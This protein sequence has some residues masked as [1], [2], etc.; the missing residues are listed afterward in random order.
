MPS[1]SSD[2]HVVGFLRLT[3]RNWVG[4]FA[5]LEATA[6]F[7]FWPHADDLWGAEEVPVLR[8]KLSFCRI[9]PLVS[10]CLSI[11]KTSSGLA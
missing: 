7:R 3:R 4:A 6:Q 2:G 10:G 1:A 8:V 9:G 5:L 11:P